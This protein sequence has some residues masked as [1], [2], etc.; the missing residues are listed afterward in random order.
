MSPANASGWPWKL[1]V[2]MTS[3]RRRP[4]GTITGLSTMEPSSI[5]TTRRQYARASRTAPCTCGAQRRRVRV[6][7]GVGGVPVAGQQRA[8]RPAAAAGWP[9]L[10]SWPGCGRIRMH[11]L[12]V[13]PVG[14]EQRLHGQRAGDVGGLGQQL[15]VGDRER[16]QGLHRLGAVDQREALLGGE[17]ERR[18]AGLGRAARRPGGRRPGRRRGAAGP[19]RPAAARPRRAGPGR[20]TRRPSPCSG[21][22]A[23]GRARAARAAGAAAPVGSRTRRRRWCGRAAAAAPRTASSGSGGPTPAACAAQQGELHPGQVVVPDWIR[24]R[25]RRSRC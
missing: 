22:P 25:A 21:P 6:L 19:R 7:D 5:S 1:P 18:Q 14:A 16:E 20:R 4:R 2:D 11:P 12:V 9:A 24:R 10:A 23:A 13:R 3:S 17:R 8:G 15:G